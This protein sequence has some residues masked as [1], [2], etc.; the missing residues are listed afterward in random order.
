MLE[1][2]V[3]DLLEFKDPISQ[4]FGFLRA[5]LVSKGIC[6]WLGNYVCFTVYLHAQKL[7]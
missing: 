3:P 2:G 4:V 7:S 5:K 6:S 1:G